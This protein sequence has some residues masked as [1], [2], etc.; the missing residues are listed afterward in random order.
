VRAGP[1][2]V[3]LFSRKKCCDELQCKKLQMEVTH[4]KKKCATFRK[5][6]ATLTYGGQVL[7]FKKKC[8]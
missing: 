6:C 7:Q 2:F 5:M 4:H 3:A 1:K 8:N